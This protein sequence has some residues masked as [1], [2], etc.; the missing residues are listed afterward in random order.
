V[1]TEKPTYK[2]LALKVKALE[3]EVARRERTDEALRRRKPIIFNDY[4]APNPLK[5]F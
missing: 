1:I 4:A 2:E 3:K 5:F